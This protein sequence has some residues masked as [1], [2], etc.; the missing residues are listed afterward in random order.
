[1]PVPLAT[2]IARYELLPARLREL[3]AL[4]PN[5]RVLYDECDDG[6]RLAILN[7]DDAYVAW[8]DV[9]TGKAEII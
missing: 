8:I 5:A 4:Y 3:S 9:L 1:M 6:L 2:L 7:A